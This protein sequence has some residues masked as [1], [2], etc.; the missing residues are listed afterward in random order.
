ML[1]VRLT[2]GATNDT[3]EMFLLESKEFAENEEVESRNKVKTTQ[4]T[5]HVESGIYQEQ[6]PIRVPANVS[7]KGDESQK[8]YC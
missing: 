6:L 3:L 2:Q 5:I 7:I 1:N 8:N 4:I